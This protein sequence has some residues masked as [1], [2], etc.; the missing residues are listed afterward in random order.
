MC[1]A[2]CSSPVRV[3]TR[4]NGERPKG[5]RKKS[6]AE[7][8]FGSMTTVPPLAAKKVKKK[9]SASERITNE[10]GSFA[11]YLLVASVTRR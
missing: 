10:G 7:E 4:N 9:V 8:N 3:E 1:N 5:K 11:I 2:V 6:R